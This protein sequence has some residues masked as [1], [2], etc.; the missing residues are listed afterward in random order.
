MKY[1]VE[2]M[3]W[4]LKSPTNSLNDTAKQR[5]HISKLRI[6]VSLWIRLLVSNEQ[7]NPLTK[8]QQR[9]KR[10]IPYNKAHGPTWDPPGA[11]R[12][13]VGPRWAPWT[14]LSGMLLRRYDIYSAYKLPLIRLSHD[15]LFG[16]LCVQCTRNRQK[17]KKTYSVIDVSSVYRSRVIPDPCG[18]PSLCVPDSTSLRSPVDDQRTSW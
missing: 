14:L 4:R 5:K 1:E 7:W 15:G 9:G 6:I 8:H 12:T 13:Q 11:D 18:T 17:Y 3:L 2:W 16:V 10:H